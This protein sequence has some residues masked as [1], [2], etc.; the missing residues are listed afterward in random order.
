MEQSGNVICRQFLTEAQTGLTKLSDSE[1][2]VYADHV[3]KPTPTAAIEEKGIRV[4]DSSGAERILSTSDRY[5]FVKV[6]GISEQTVCVDSVTIQKV[7][8]DSD[9]RSFGVFNLAEQNGNWSFFGT[10]PLKTKLVCA[11]AGQDLV[12]YVS[13]NDGQQLRVLDL[14]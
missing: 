6:L 8:H 1:L 13:E 12:A 9:Y 2:H 14:P 3:F 7:E 4:C 11:A 10:H 5:T